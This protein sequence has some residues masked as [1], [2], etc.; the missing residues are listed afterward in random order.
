MSS[1]QLAL[2]YESMVERHELYAKYGIAAEAAQLFETE[3][4]TLLLCLRALDKGWHIVPDGEAAQETLDE[5]D[6]ST[7]GRLLHNLKRHIK[8]EGD[9]EDGFLSALEARNRLSHGFFERHNLKIQTE[10]G[11]KE[12]V[13]DLDRLHRELFHA[14]RSA[15]DLSTIIAEL[16]GRSAENKPPF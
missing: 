8:I 4:G 7:L 3:L 6:R 11:R 10:H 1:S 12:M 9:L 14:W 15:G 5:I 13:A 2:E 16:V